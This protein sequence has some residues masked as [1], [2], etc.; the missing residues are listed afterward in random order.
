MKLQF[1][2]LPIP[3]KGNKQTTVCPKKTYETLSQDKIEAM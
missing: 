1:S 3:K 2:V